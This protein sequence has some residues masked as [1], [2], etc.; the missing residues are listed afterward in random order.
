[1]KGG[2]TLPSPFTMSIWE[3][4]QGHDWKF[5]PRAR[6]IDA[7]LWHCTRGGQ[8]YPGWKEFN[9]SLNWFRSPNNITK[10]ARFEPYAG[11]S[12][13]VIGPEHICEVVPLDRIPAFSS[14][15]ADEHAIS[16]EVCQSNPGQ[17]IEEA[18]IANCVKFARWCKDEYGIEL[19]RTTPESDWAW[20]GMTG[21]EDLVQGKASG[22]SD[23]GPVFWAAFMEALED[24]G[25]ELRERVERLER[26][27]GA[28]G[29]DF[30]YTGE[31]MTGEA[32][33]VEADRRGFSAFLGIGIA[34]KDIG[35]HQAAPHG[36]DSVP[37]HQH[38]GV[39]R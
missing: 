14:H 38:G 17:P 16:V 23:P 37:E 26:L 11:I 20:T 7:L 5:R 29:I 21:H 6:E 1:M 10:V 35:E 12:H 28:N 25:M 30:D 18:T 19:V 3:D 24:E 22:K 13:V 15:P 9:A 39:V 33:L 34:R 31:P 8:W 2:R 4:V 36:S 32:A 27:L